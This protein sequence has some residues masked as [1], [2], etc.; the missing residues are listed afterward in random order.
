MSN[1]CS[2]QYQESI[3]IVACMLSLILTRL[4][5]WQRIVRHVN[6]FKAPYWSR[7]CMHISSQWHDCLHVQAS[8]CMD[9][10]TNGKF[11]SLLSHKNSSI[12]SL[13]MLAC[14]DRYMSESTYHNQML[15]SSTCKSIRAALQLNF[16]DA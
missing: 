1:E 4:W 2:D 12:I 11:A 9:N 10:L 3:L 8:N 13:C 6:C 5:N 14:D 15:I 16:M 7:M